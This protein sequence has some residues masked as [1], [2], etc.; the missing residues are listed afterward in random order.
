MNIREKL[1]KMK[2]GESRVFAFPEEEIDAITYDAYK[3]QHPKT[4]KTKDDPSFSDSPRHPK[5]IAKHEEKKKEN[6]QHVD[7]HLE[8]SGAE[9]EHKNKLHSLLNHVSE[10]GKE[11]KGED[12]AK[13]HLEDFKSGKNTKSYEWIKGKEGKPS[14]SVPNFHAKPSGEIGK[15]KPNHMTEDPF[16][17][18]NESKYGASKKLIQ[19]HV[20]AGKPAQIHTSSDKLAHD[21]YVN[22]LKKLPKGSIVNLYYQDE[23]KKNEHGHPSNKRIDETAKKLKAAGINVKLHK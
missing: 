10:F 15:G 11:Y 22:E 23:E 2:L 13:K 8:G 4:T 17:Y 3:K 14:M 12:Q 5:N 6:K 20:K 1:S 19:E 16:A 21:D 18:S 7:K 9:E